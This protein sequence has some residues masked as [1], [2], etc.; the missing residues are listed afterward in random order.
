MSA[1][2]VREYMTAQPH[3]IGRNQP[4]AVAHQLMQKRRIRHLP[5]L[6]GGKLVGMVTMR[7][8]HFIETFA[9]VDVETVRV[10]DAMSDEPYA[11]GPDVRL[12][13]VA[14]TMAKRRYGSAV[15]MEAGEVI[16]V[17]TTTDALRALSELTGRR[18]RQ[19]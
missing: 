8:L 3:T 18:A 9:D 17:F 16:G 6:D 5:V 1:A 13:T 7:D 2:T 14:A 10:E 19:G 4:L 11:V 12:S 15:V